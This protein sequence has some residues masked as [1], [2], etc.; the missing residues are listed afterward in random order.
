MTV[1][2][3]EVKLTT[4]FKRDFRLAQRRGLPMALLEEVILRELYA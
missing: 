4:Y 1:T 3:Y 2:K